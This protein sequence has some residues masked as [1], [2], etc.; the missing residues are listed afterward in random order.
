VPPEPL[1]TLGE[2]LS[3]PEYSNYSS[4]LI[5]AGFQEDF[6]QLLKYTV[7]AP[8]NDAFTAAGYDV[9]A[10]LADV[11]GNADE[12]AEL[13]LVLLNTIAAG[14]LAIEN[15]SN[16]QLMLSGELLPVVNEGG[17]VTIGGATITG[18]SVVASNGIVHQL[19]QLPPR[20]QPL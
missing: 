3:A 19:G 12:A 5:A 9:A 8:T 16:P 11:A 13:N 15:L 18:A 10:I 6:E 14:S 4:L 2:V 17:T 20:P 1:P 7:F